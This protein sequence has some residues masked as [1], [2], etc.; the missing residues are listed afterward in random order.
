M[1]TVETNEMQDK[2]I[3]GMKELVKRSLREE[4]GITYEEYDSY[5]KSFEKEFG[6]H[7]KDKSGPENSN[8]ER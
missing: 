3:P 2:Q 8:N 7:D 4:N 5:Q 6:R 1:E